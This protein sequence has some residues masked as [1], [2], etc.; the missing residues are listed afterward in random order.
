M[1]RPL[2]LGQWS[3]IPLLVAN[4]LDGRIINRRNQKLKPR[5]G[6]GQHVCSVNKP[7]L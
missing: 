5:T 2:E 1:T 6:M 3:Q 4:R 7:V